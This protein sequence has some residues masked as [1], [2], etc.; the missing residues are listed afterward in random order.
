MKDEEIEEKAIKDA[1]FRDILYW[2]QER[3]ESVLFEE[4]VQDLETASLHAGD[5]PGE[6]EIVTEF[7]NDRPMRQVEIK[8]KGGLDEV[9]YY[10]VEDCKDG[11]NPQ[12]AL[13]WAEF[14]EQAA[15]DLREAATT[16]APECR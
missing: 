16:A 1:G 13:A 14:L 8:V 15:K 5:I 7:I 4:A 10:L 3:F 9:L 12:K 2:F 11:R 6:L